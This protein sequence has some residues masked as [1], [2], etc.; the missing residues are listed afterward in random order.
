MSAEWMHTSFEDGSLSAQWNQIS[1][2]GVKP[3]A[4]LWI[5]ETEHFYQW[6]PVEMPEALIADRETFAGA[7]TD[8][9]FIWREEAGY[10]WFWSISILKDKPGFTVRATFTNHS[11]EPIRW[12]NFTLLHSVDKGLACKGDPSSWHLSPFAHDLRVGHLGETLISSNESTVAMWEGFGMPVPHALETGS[13]ANDGRWRSYEDYASLYTDQGRQGIVIGAVGAPEADIRLDF[14]VTKGTMKLVATSEMSGIIVYP[15]ET[16]EA[17]ELLVLG[18]PYVTAAETMLRWTA[19]THGA[20]TSAGSRFG[21]CS[22][23]DLMDKITE[24]SILETTERI[25]DLKQRLPF[26]VIQIDDGYQLETGDWRCNHKF[27]NGLLPIV[28]KIK[29]TGAEPGI[30]LAPLA[31]H[32]RCGL[33]GL[34]PD[35]FQR[36]VK[37]ELEGQA[38]NW[39]PTSHWLDP[40]HPEVKAMLRQMIQDKKA[41]GF[42]YFKID[43]NTIG[44]KVRLYDKHKTR[45]QAFRELYQL[46]RE[47]IGEMGYL[48]ACSGFTRGVA[49]YAD[50]ARI[51]PDSAAFWSAAHSCTILECIRSVGM[52]AIA[53]GILFANDPDVTY[54]QPRN[55]LTED[56]LR[57]WHGFVGL[58]G[59][60]SLVSEPLQQTTMQSPEAMRKLEWLR[61]SSPE[62][63]LPLRPG[64]ERNTNHFGF[65][66]TRMEGNRFIAIQLFNDA[67]QSTDI[68]LDFPGLDEFDNK[69][70]AWSFWDGAY[71]GLIDRSYISRGIPPHGSRLLRLTAANSTSHPLLIGSD[72]HISLG[73]AEIA[74]VR[75]DAEDSTYEITFTDAGTRS[76]RLYLYAEQ[77]VSLIAANGCNCSVHATSTDHVWSIAIEGRAGNEQ[78]VKLGGSD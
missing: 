5:G 34:K 52:N 12:N 60:L 4:T 30:W 76:G 54:I 32:D 19:N 40:T 50:S 58:L 35:Y 62:R 42:T 17:Q 38:S 2:S 57:T 33:L 73:A 24:S 39:G 63:G 21:W 14:Q 10:E 48:L 46:Y 67:E 64:T 53:N 7:A 66:S 43:F 59:G 75:S 72:L 69:F 41:D 25:A 29:E 70:H 27:P 26:D 47:E 78:W 51:G 9:Q 45:L 8:Y 49:G 22:W 18:G 11:G 44:R 65:I 6:K 61:P 23:Y 13:K 74:E 55:A 71:I 16:R 36:N 28:L 20:R 1:L 37:G 31:M 15:G 77:K 3:Q 56:E 68:P